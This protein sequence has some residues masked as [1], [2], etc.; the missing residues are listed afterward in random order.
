MAENEALDLSG[1]SGRWRRLVK[2]IGSD[3]PS[4]QIADDAVQCLYRTFKNLVE[5][6]ALGQSKGWEWA[7]WLPASSAA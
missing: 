2:R 7:G 1:N 6:L 3:E 4:G 5:L